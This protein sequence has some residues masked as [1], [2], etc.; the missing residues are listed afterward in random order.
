[1]TPNVV[2][3]SRIRCPRS[4]TKPASTMISATLPSSDGWKL[5]KPIW[6]QR[7]EP[8]TSAATT[9]TTSRR[10]SEPVE[11]PADTP[12]RARVDRRGREED[13][14]D[15]DV[16]NLPEDVVVRISGHVVL[17]HGLEHPEPVGEQSTGGED[18]QVVDVSQVRAEL[19]AAAWT[20]V[21][22]WTRVTGVAIGALPLVALLD[23]GGVAAWLDVEVLLEHLERDR[24]GRGTSV[25]SVLD[26]RA[27]R[28]LGLV[29]GP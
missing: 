15:G 7:F 13:R 14:T 24:R 27:D 3:H 25:A 22:S 18:Q 20:R 6:I 9:K 29:V 1:M 4:A 12:V 10:T 23:H 28:D 26:Q 5:K 11:G 16:D 21:G 8:R 2:L 17:R 19:P